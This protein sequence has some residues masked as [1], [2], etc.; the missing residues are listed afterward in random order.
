MAKEPRATAAKT[1]AR[2]TDL[3]T[4]R[5]IA[6]PVR[7]RLYEVLATGGPATASKLSAYVPGAPGSLS[8]HL[9][10]L[11]EHGYIEE[12]PELGKDGRERWWRAIPGGVRWS[13]ADFEG[14]PAGREA[15]ASAQQVLVARQ[16]ERLHAWQAAG[17]EQWG[18]DWAGAA[19]AT[20]TVL[21][22][23]L[24]ELREFAADLHAVMNKWGE[25]SRAAT[26]GARRGDDTDREQVFVFTHAFPFDDR[27]GPSRGSP[28]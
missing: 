7:L 18:P 27:P 17:A 16:L 12:A 8:Y 26:Q 25:A 3:R 24:D 5:A 21:H 20:D 22:L 14:Q 6:H 11:A 1:T 13:N 2:I 10:Q 15:L 28:A 19:V 23:S 9:R 4:L